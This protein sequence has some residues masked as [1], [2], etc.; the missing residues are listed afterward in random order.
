MQDFTITESRVLASHLDNSVNDRLSELKLVTLISKGKPRE[1][2]RKQRLG[3]M[4]PVYT[5]KTKD[6]LLDRCVVFGLDALLAHSQI[7]YNELGQPD[8]DDDYFIH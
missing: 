6:A 3:I 7:P 5:L 4:F 1:F 8:D 2:K